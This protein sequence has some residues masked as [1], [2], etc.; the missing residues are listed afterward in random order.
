MACVSMPDGLP[1]AVEVVSFGL[2]RVPVSP[3]IVVQILVVRILTLSLA[4]VSHQHGVMRRREWLEFV[5][6][7]LLSRGR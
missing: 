5:H 4:G 6:D 7:A 3:R 1:A 2:A